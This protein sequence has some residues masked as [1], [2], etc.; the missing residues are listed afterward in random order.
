M[1]AA[2]GTDDGDGIHPALSNDALAENLAEAGA[3]LVLVGLTHWPLDRT[4]GGVRVMI[5]IL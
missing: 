2:P 5:E 3:D 4:A 1:H